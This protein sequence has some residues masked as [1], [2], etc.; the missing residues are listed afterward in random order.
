MD[1]VDDTGRTADMDCAI[2]ETNQETTQ[3]Y[4]Q[5]VSPT[6]LQDADGDDER[7]PTRQP[8]QLSY[9]AT[10]DHVRC[11]PFVAGPRCNVGH[12][13]DQSSPLEDL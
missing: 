8:N 2:A 1:E 10:T 3:T 5:R 6:P 13:S 9:A 4:T 12:T 7:G 11:L